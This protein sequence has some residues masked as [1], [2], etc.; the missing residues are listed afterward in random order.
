MQYGDQY[1]TEFLVS[2][3]FS[4][5]FCVQNKFKSIFLHFQVS[6][7]PDRGWLTMYF[8]LAGVVQGNMQFGDHK[9]TLEACAYSTEVYAMCV[10]LKRWQYLVHEDTGR[11]WNPLEDEIWNPSKGK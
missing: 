10:I 5:Y 7:E 1:I 3:I 9:Y 8:N 2:L 11:F 4:K 6:G